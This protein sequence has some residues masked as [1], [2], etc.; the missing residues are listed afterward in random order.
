MNCLK[1]AGLITT[2]RNGEMGIRR[3]QFAPPDLILL[4]VMMPGI[5]GF[6]TCRRLKADETTRDVPI[7]FITVM[8]DVESKLKGFEAGGVDY[9]TKP[10]EEREVLARVRTHLELQRARKTLEL[11]NRQ[12]LETSRCGKMSN[13]S[14]IT[15][16]RLSRRPGIG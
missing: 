16:S 14:P 7:I 1:T 10:I 3:A 12:L 13:A 2:A 4:D 5:D 8:K 15:I 11:Y 6:E 9:V